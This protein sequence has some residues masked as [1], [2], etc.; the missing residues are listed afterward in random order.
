M[1]EIVCGIGSSRRDSRNKR[2][3][4]ASFQ[5]CHDHPGRIR[6]AHTATFK[7]QRGLVQQKRLSHNFSLD[8]R[9]NAG[10][11]NTRTRLWMSERRRMSSRVELLN[12]FQQ[13]LRCADVLKRRQPDGSRSRRPTVLVT[14]H[15][16]SCTRL[17]ALRGLF[18][19]S[20]IRMNDFMLCDMFAYVET[21]ALMWF[22]ALE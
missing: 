17:V 2:R 1:G 10:S 9:Q 8:H 16:S 22:I 14:R 5:K 11:Q 18:V 15:T 6:S 12:G 20:S 4:N 19:V 21:T 3:M 7:Q 13:F